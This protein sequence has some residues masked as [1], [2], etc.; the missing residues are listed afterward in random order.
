MV[1]NINKTSANTGLLKKA[2]TDLNISRHNT[3]I[4]PR[5]HPIVEK[6]LNNAFESM[7]KFLDFREEIT[8]TIARNNFIVDDRPL[9]NDNRAFKE[10]ALC[11][12]RMSIAYVMFKKGL[13]LDELYSF[14]SFIGTDVKDVSAEK[15]QGLLK[16]HI[17]VH[18]SIG[19]IDYSAFNLDEN[20][21]DQEEKQD[22]HSIWVRYVKGLMEGTLRT[23]SAMNE[24]R[25]IPPEKFSEI[26]NDL[27]ACDIEDDKLKRAA[28]AYVGNIISISFSGRE[29]K[30]LLNITTG[31]RA[32][33]KKQF[34][35]SIINTFSEDMESSEKAI[36]DISPM[37]IDDL[38]S[39][40]NDNMVSVPDALK[41]LLDQFSGISEAR[42]ESPVYQG[43]LIEDD[44]L[45]T[46][47]M[48]SLLG[49]ATYKSFVSDTYQ[50][51]IRH[52][53]K[54]DSERMS[55]EM[56][57]EHEKDFSDEYIERD[58]NRMILE[59]T[60]SNRPDIIQQDDLELFI[61]ILRDQ[62]EQFIG[63]GQYKQ[64]LETIRV[65]ESKATK[66]MP[67]DSGSSVLQYFHSRK[68]ISSLI[69]S[70]RTMGRQLKED[71]LLLCDYYGESIIP[72]L[73]DSLITEQSQSI[74]RFLISLVTHFADMS[75]P[76]IIKRLSDNRWFVKR[77]MLFILAECGSK[78]SLLKAK[79]YCNVSHP[80]VS[81]EAIKCLLKAGDNYAVNALKGHLHSKD[82]DSVKK[83]ITL[84]GSFKINELVP[85]LI[86]MLTKKALKNKDIESKIPVV[87]ALG[88]IG[89]TRALNV[90]RDISSTKSLLFRGSMEKLKKEIALSLKQNFCERNRDSERQGIN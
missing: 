66:K 65:L 44:I 60:L 52:I 78:E 73:L 84:A 55:R 28:S 74:R 12:G 13:M 56:S 57:K 30:K 37:E 23:D 42:S 4:Y 2:I 40:I 32:D 15:L 5:N 27:A 63:T 47:E 49:E 1:N 80:K 19:F 31:L 10:F 59:L 25:T 9:E 62:V 70:F 82:E 90:L 45:Q 3:S 50:Q 83:A 75:S 81:F 54:P 58:F 33:L 72:Y 46:P 39:I 67:D 22:E 8:L 18:I 48:T 79:P 61:S 29:F 43:S 41:N 53:I 14:L 87:R 76:E 36:R 21:T 6:S 64:V 88:Q 16:K 69:D 17:L 11:L 24:I 89:G 38:I 68:F 34:L 7:Q 51:E 20:G 71:V 86:Q 35:S 26:L 77:N 85:D